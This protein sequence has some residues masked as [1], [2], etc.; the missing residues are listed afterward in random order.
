MTAVRKNPLRINNPNNIPSILTRD[1]NVTDTSPL[2]STNNVVLVGT[3]ISNVNN[4]TTPS[5]HGQ[6][7]KITLNNISSFDL[8]LKSELRPSSATFDLVDGRKS[9]VKEENQDIFD[10]EDE[11]VWEDEVVSRKTSQTTALQ[12]LQ[13]SQNTNVN[14]MRSSRQLSSSLI[15]IANASTSNNISPK[16]SLLTR[17]SSNTSFP[18]ISNGSS[19]LRQSIA[20][21]N[22]FTSLTP[23]STSSSSAYKTPSPTLY[24]M[25]DTVSSVSRPASVCSNHSTDHQQKE[26]ESFVASTP[27]N[28]ATERSVTREGGTRSSQ[29]RRSSITRSPHPFDNQL[30]TTN[31]S[32]TPDSLPVIS[33]PSTDHKLPSV[34]PTSLKKSTVYGKSDILSTQQQEA[35]TP[36]P[37]QL[38]IS[39]SSRTPSQI[40]KS[41]SPL[42]VQEINML[43][44]FKVKKA[45]PSTKSPQPVLHPLHGKR[46]LKVP[47][48]PSIENDTTSDITA[49]IT[50]NTSLHDEEIAPTQSDHQIITTRPSSDL[51][52]HTI[53]H[54]SEDISSTSPQT[55][56]H[57]Q[58]SASS[59]ILSPA[60]TKT[61]LI[62]SKKTVSQ[63]DDKP[64]QVNNEPMTKEQL[65]EIALVDIFPNGFDTS[66]KK[67]K[68]QQTSDQELTY[69]D[70]VNELKTLSNRVVML[71]RTESGKKNSFKNLYHFQNNHPAMDEINNFEVEKMEKRIKR[72]N[73]YRKILK[74]GLSG[75]SD[76]KSERDSYVALRRS[77]L[78]EEGFSN[79]EMSK[80]EEEVEIKRFDDEYRRFKQR[81]NPEMSTKFVKA[82]ERVDP[83][84][85]ASSLLENLFS[86]S[87]KIKS[88]EDK[89][90]EKEKLTAE[91]S[92][93]KQRWSPATTP[94]RSAQASTSPKSF[95][96]LTSSSDDSIF[97]DSEGDEYESES[98]SESEKDDGEGDDDFEIVIINDLEPQDE[99]GFFLTSTFSDLSNETLN[100][101]DS[102]KLLKAIVDASRKEA[103]V[104][105]TKPSLLQAKQQ[106]G[107]TPLILTPSISVPKKEHEQYKVL[108]RLSPKRNAGMSFDFTPSS[109][110]A[111]RTTVDENFVMKVNVR[112]SRVISANNL[113]R[114]HG[115]EVEENMPQ[116]L[117]SLEPPS[118]REIGVYHR[119]PSPSA[120]DLVRRSREVAMVTNENGRL[121]Q[122]SF[123]AT[124]DTNLGSSVMTSSDQLLNESSFLAESLEQNGTIDWKKEAGMMQQK[125]R[126]SVCEKVSDE[127]DMVLMNDEEKTKRAEDGDVIM[128][129]SLATFDDLSSPQT[130]GEADK[131]KFQFNQLL[132]H[133]NS[134]V[135]YSEKTKKKKK[136]HKK[137]SVK[138]IETVRNDESR[139]ESPTNTRHDNDIIE[140]DPNMTI[141]S[142][143]QQLFQLPPDGSK[144]LIIEL[145]EL[146]GIGA[147]GK[148]FKG[149]IPNYITNTKTQWPLRS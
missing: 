136:K 65:K 125:R 103:K 82:V 137:H 42:S 52:P 87:D 32:S 101:V 134:E 31:N 57:V 146:L 129:E 110:D 144:K 77:S 123:N 41:S 18:S 5:H 121:R 149:F 108:P 1:T 111:L 34:R 29:S 47:L 120:S 49:P 142:D 16:A 100:Q 58:N 145:D 11:T 72:L 94:K 99:D 124:E 66:N 59:T 53:R 104:A 51:V 138:S 20:S 114:Y 26:D 54:F 102:R 3:S 140:E 79:V 25:V 30:T 46:S 9:N 24:E 76:Y 70:V 75:W 113:S 141:T 92:R 109:S 60:K 61:P 23:I 56:T 139:P 4:N 96:E 43:T 68:Y 126:T 84:E 112:E 22:K 106:P 118:E 27:L 89:V 78:A 80:E 133:L 12:Q 98:T 40:K 67:I 38:P 62:I 131:Q 130:M 17:K 119:A 73:Y 122:S 64:Q 81:L 7:K 36:Q 115:K 143:Q 8:D 14:N 63:L 6:Q 91:I 88:E 132:Q 45:S 39:N 135:E 44:Q 28:T 33:S 86:R 116:K 69:T 15:N 117:S 21:V 37:V 50:T 19:S 95:S 83:H 10:H 2:P 127:D 93:W 13:S 35:T 74:N 55:P 85:V 147:H 105:L 71:K 107:M 148:V 90:V 97:S 128:T 48:T